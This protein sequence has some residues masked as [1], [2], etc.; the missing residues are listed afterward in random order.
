MATKTT[1]LYQARHALLK[2]PLPSIRNLKVEEAD[3]SIIIMGRVESYYEK[4]M[5]Q[6]AI[7]AVCQDIELQNDVD[8]HDV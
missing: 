5:A 8:V 2:S 1:Y 3:G 6:E 7:R 4:Q